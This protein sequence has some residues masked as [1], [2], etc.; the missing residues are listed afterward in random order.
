MIAAK[1]YVGYLEV[2][3]LYYSRGPGVLV[4]SRFAG[5][6][7]QFAGLLDERDRRTFRVTFPRGYRI[8][9]VNTRRSRQDSLL[10]L[11]SL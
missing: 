9:R 4:S 10:L 5:N 8:M 1:A 3:R 7:D 6:V 11:P 2:P